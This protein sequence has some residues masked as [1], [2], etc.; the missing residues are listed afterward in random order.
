MAFLVNAPKQ[1]ATT[2]V[3][4]VEVVDSTGTSTAIASSVVTSV[5][6]SATSVVLLAS[7]A[8]RKGATFYNDSAAILYLAF[9]A[10]ASAAAYTVQMVANAYFELPWPVY[11]G[12]ISG[13]W[14]SATGAVKITELS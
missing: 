7:N 9:A 6:A 11:T 14:V 8:S 5:N 4:Q 3:L 13:I 12:V 2:D 1:N 10:T